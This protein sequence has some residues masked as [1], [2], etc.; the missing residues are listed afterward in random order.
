M[1]FSN[2]PS[3]DQFDAPTAALEDISGEYTI[4]PTHT[5]LGFSTRYAMISTV[6]GQF[7]DFAGTA[8]IDAA[9]PATPACS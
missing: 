4:D 6:R 2:S 8:T 7:T 9:N 1:S 5:R 3:T